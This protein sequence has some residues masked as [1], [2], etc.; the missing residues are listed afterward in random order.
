[1]KA[2]ETTCKSSCFP[3]MLKPNPIL[4]FCTIPDNQA[5][6]LQSI[7]YVCRSFSHM[8]TLFPSLFRIDVG[9]MTVVQIN[10]ISLRF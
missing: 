3:I 9:E 5:P 7:V 4:T 10:A 6:V 1:M 2:L 8:I